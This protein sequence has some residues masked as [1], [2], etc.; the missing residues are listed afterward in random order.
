MHPSVIRYF[1]NHRLQDTYASKPGAPL[2]TRQF[3]DYPDM[4]QWNEQGG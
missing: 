1:D 3:G 2:P 4:E